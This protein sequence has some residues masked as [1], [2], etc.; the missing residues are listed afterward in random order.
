MCSATHGVEGFAGSALQTGLLDDGIGARLGA[1]T[2]LVLIHAI[3]PYGFAHL[4]RAN[5]DNVDLNRNF[6]DHS[7][8]QPPNPHYAALAE[9]I[10]PRRWW[11]GSRAA[12]LGRLQ[13][14]RTFR[15]RAALHAAVT[16]GQ[17]V[18]PQGHFY[19]GRSETWSNRTLRTIVEGH[20]SGVPRVGFVDFHTGL[21]PHGHGEVIVQDP[22]GSPAASRAK[23]W[24]GDRVKLT[25]A[26][27]AVSA[28]L[29]G[30]L[31][32]SISSML[33]E[34][35]VTAAVLE[36]G[37]SPAMQVFRAMQAENWLH[38]YG[39]RDTAGG[40]AIKARMRAVFYPDTDLWKARV[41]RQGKE[42]VEQALNALND[43]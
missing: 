39:G 2:G 29:S 41:W 36:F 8:A 10:A 37:T 3:N 28:E 40:D 20:L 30:L 33:P 4:R 27:E 19:G 32:L 6:V 26:G 1:E 9:A 22:P 24:W 16:G 23:E 7:K 5:E 34:A 42:V 17:Y 12:S 38:H 15:G 18:Y 43:A 31:K 21:G 25:Q 11:L 13:W 35:E 14:I